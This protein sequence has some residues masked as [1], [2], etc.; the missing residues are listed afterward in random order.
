LTSPKCSIPIEIGIKLHDEDV[1]GVKDLENIKSIGIS[2]PDN[3]CY[4]P[5][6]VDLCF[7]RAEIFVRPVSK[8]QKYK[9]SS[10]SILEFKEIQMYDCASDDLVSHNW[11]WVVSNA[12]GGAFCAPNKDQKGVA[13]FPAWLS[14]DCLR[15]SSDMVGKSKKS[16][17][18]IDE[19]DYQMICLSIFSSF[20]IRNILPEGVEWEV[21]TVLA[22]DD[23]TMETKIV[24]GSSLRKHQK[25]L[26]GYTLSENEEEDSHMIRSGGRKEVL[27]C[28][29]STMK[30]NV[31]F[32]CNSE[33]MWTNWILINVED[34]DS[35]NKGKDISLQN[36]QGKYY[37]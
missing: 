5:L 8:I 23:A 34:E 32:R 19:I 31:R 2:S 20:S 3:Y 11:R 18:P 7:Q 6:W 30:V 37:H 22:S 29:T 10:K 35:K 9:W 24:D 27:A 15:G 25:K 4:L 12:D 36:E 33:N 26:L 21:S 14:Y 13:I 16:S 17:L 28:D 1:T